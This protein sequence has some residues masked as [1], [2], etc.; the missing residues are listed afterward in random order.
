MD[1]RGLDS[2]AD[3]H[4]LLRVLSVLLL[5]IVGAGL[6]TWFMYTLIL[7]GDR[8]L[9]DSGRAHMIEFVR[10]KRDE[11]SQIKDRRPERPQVD[12]QPP[13]PATPDMDSQS[14]SVL[15]VSDALLPDGLGDGMGIGGLGFDSSDGEYLP[16]VKVAP[17]YPHRALLQEL[18]GEC[19]VIYSVTTNGSTRDIKVVESMCTHKVFWTPSVA[20]AKKFKYKPRVID[21]EPVEVHGVTNRFIFELADAPGL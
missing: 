16:I 6:L 3:H 5:G 1:H 10:I 17:V 9:D 19:V 4:Y 14:D 2:F 13:A 15:S 18:E 21:G 20:A 7:S 12:E 8:R 11:T